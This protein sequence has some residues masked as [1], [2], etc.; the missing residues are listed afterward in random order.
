MTLLVGVDVGASHTEA[1]VSDPSLD[2]I[3][4]HRGGEAALAPTNLSGSVETINQVIQA[5]IV[6]AD[7][8]TA[9]GGVVVGAAGA[10]QRDTRLAVEAALRET[11][12]VDCLVK[13]TTDGEIALQSAFGQEAGIT[14][15]AGSG[16]IAYARDRSG[17]VWRA[18]GLGWQFGDE[19]SGYAL[20]RAALAAVGQA[21]DGR[22]PETELAV[23]LA[24]AVGEESPHD[25]VRWAQTADRSA[26]AM[27]ATIVSHWASR[28]DPVAARLV[29]NAARDLAW[30]VAALARHFPA[31]TAIPVAV[32]GGVLSSDNPVRHAFSA[33]L[34]ELVPRATLS[35]ETVDPAMG[36]LV[37]ALAAV[38]GRSPGTDGH[39]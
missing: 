31:E 34:Q 19:G 4:R 15:C 11:W 23:A 38:E 9:V 6:K 8:G 12:G 33:V 39:E 14:L 32:G 25:V 3:T 35:N 13:V 7:Q 29:Y 16:S 22:G 18:G 27:L 28:G 36:A 1:A 17:H 24:R 26:V 2:P 5:A 21:A 30:H 37:M 20:A 10:G